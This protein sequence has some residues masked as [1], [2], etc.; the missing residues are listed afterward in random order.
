MKLPRRQRGRRII[1]NPR[2][3][4]GLLALC[5]S[6]LPGHAQGFSTNV[7]QTP[8]AQ[9]NP[10]RAQADA[11]LEAH[12][13]ARALKFLGPLAEANPKDAPTLYDLATAQDALDQNS[14][15]EKSYRASIADDAA[16]LDPRVALGL[17]LARAGR[18]AEARTELVAATQVSDGEPV[19]KARAYRA[20]ARID[21]RTHPGDARDELL[22]ALKLSPETT[23]DTLLAAELAARAEGGAPAAEAAYRRVLAVHPD[24]PAAVAGLAHLLVLNKREAEAEALLAGALKTHPDDPQLTAELAGL[25]DS[26]RKIA[27]AIPLFEKLQ[28]ADPGNVDV[29]LPLAEL[30]LETQDFAKAEP[31]LATLARDRPQDTDIIDDRARALIHLHRSAEAEAI[32]APIVAQPKLFPTPKDLGDAAGDL[33][34]ACSQNNDPTCTLQALD[35]RATVLPISAPILFL[36]AISHD[37]LHHVKLAIQAYNQFLEAS[38]GN[39]PDQESEARHRLVTL[40]HMK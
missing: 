35:V 8:T 40:E 34:F 4:I 9:P 38:Q 18:F 17:M 16:F 14:A 28:K 19:L 29:G 26:E 13:Y 10:I 23:E 33:A 7:T 2:I 5:L 15:A 3:S 25:Y 27:L 6:A 30:Y 39:N 24:D 22:E 37:K 12:D 21:E 11:A 32:L 31:L 1:V 20:L 36:S